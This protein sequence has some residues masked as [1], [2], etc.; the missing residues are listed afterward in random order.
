MSFKPVP[1]YSRQA[2]QF[3]TTFLGGM[4]QRQ[5]ALERALASKALRSKAVM[6]GAELKADALEYAGK[7]AGDAAKWGGIMSAVGSIGK[8][9]VGGLGN[10]GGD[11]DAY[12]T[13]HGI[14]TGHATAIHD[15]GAFWTTDMPVNSY[16]PIRPGATDNQ[17]FGTP[18]W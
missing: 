10:M 14:S 5:M 8:G 17:I 12:A 3:N 16:I 13:D 2:S 18:T 7:Q 9:I 15:G 1:G 11:M 6:E 4:P